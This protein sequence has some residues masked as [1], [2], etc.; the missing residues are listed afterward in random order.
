MEKI[1]HEGASRARCELM[2][3]WQNLQNLNS[4]TRQSGFKSWLHHSCVIF[5]KLV[6]AWNH[7]LAQL[8]SIQV[9]SCISKAGMLKWP[10]PLHLQGMRCVFSSTK[11]MCLN[12]IWEG[13]EMRG[14][15]MI[16]DLAVLLPGSGEETSHWLCGCVGKQTTYGAGRKLKQQPL[17]PLVACGWRW[18]FLRSLVLITGSWFPTFPLVEV[19]GLAVQSIAWVFLETEPRSCLLMILETPNPLW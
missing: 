8:T 16:I 5:E 4:G 9:S 19:A 17:W 15:H 2:G 12:V 18:V 14:G 7:R 1:C 13:K 11:Q 3:R 6:N 10:T